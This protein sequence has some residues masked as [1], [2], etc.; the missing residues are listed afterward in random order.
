MSSTF[1][2]Q[3]KDLDKLLSSAA[4]CRAWSSLWDDLRDATDSAYDLPFIFM[5]LCDSRGGL[6]LRQTLETRINTGFQAISQ[7]SERVK[8]GGVNQHSGNIFLKS[9][10]PNCSQQRSWPYHPRPED[11]AKK[12]G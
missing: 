10:F 7:G 9:L 2:K 1:F 4:G 11:L 12:L 8:P 5:A 6:R 3:N